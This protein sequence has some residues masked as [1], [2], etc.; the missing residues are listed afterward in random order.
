MKPVKMKFVIVSPPQASG[1]SIVLHLLCKLL[2]EKGY[3]ARIVRIGPHSLQNTSKF[4]FLWKYI[5][6]QLEDKVKELT[7]RF[8]SHTDYIKNHK[9]RYA[10]YAYYPVKG[11][12]RKWLPFVDDDTIVVYP[13]IVWGNIL[14]AKHIVRWILGA[15][16]HAFMD[17]VGGYED[18]DV[19]I[20]YREIFNVQ[21][22]N[23]E[24]KTVC[25]H[26]FDYDLYRQTNFGTRDGICYIIRKGSTRSDLPKTFDG[27]IIDDMNEREIVEVFNRCE[28]CLSYDTQTFYTTIAAVCGCL[29][30]VMLE[31]GKT[32]SDYVG[33][34]DH[35]WGI[36]YGNSPEE[37]SFARATRGELL[38]KI[39][40]FR[41]QNE[42]NI[43][44]FLKICQTYYER[45]AHGK[46]A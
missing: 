39:Q 1:G 17:G 29:P 30:I 44:N 36:S 37:I 2:A 3:D 7:Y 14:G 24:K 19:F 43:N 12:K 28:Y 16:P 34:D 33:A 8:F 4:Y 31:P 25:L 46:P 18:T 6:F 15:S 40:A 42:N 26:N 45:T 23:P 5:G 22:L 35:T 27:P 32:K 38:H 20:C 9:G 10:W 13:E 41:L 11:C 21:E